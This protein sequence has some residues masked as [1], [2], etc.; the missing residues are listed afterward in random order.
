MKKLYSA[1]LV[2]AIA[3]VAYWINSAAES[4]RTD[5]AQVAPAIAGSFD[6][7]APVDTR[8]AALEQAVRTERQARHLLQEEVFFLTDWAYQSDANFTLYDAVEF[9]D[10][11]VE[12]GLR[13]GY[14]HNDGQYEVALYGRNITDDESLIGQIDF[15]NITGFVNMPALWGIEFTARIGQ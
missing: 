7:T 12:G 9:K 15:N 5:T 4:T 11:M 1:I 14:A 3:C 8:L 2:L 10:D 13:I 6:D